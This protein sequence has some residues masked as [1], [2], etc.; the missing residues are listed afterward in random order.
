MLVQLVFSPPL[1]PV[2]RRLLPVAPIQNES[3]YGTCRLVSAHDALWRMLWR[4][5]FNRRVPRGLVARANAGAG[6]AGAVA[7]L[8][9]G[10]WRNA[11]REAVATAHKDELWT[12]RKKKA[13]ATMDATAV[14]LRLPFHFAVLFLNGDGERD[15]C[16]AR[17]RG[18]IS[19]VQQRLTV[20]LFCRQASAEGRLERCVHPSAAILPARVQFR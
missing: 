19:R 11:F 9:I 16:G 7:G 14:M 3:R 5:R 10:W 12:L 1:T 2:P 15:C 8:Q 18:H 6:G 4:Q 13:S 20:P 17:Q